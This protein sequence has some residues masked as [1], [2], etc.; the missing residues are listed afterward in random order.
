MNKKNRGRN[1]SQKKFRKEVERKEE[2]DGVRERG[3]GR[4][5]GWR[6]VD[7]GGGGGG[8]WCHFPWSCRVLKWFLRWHPGPKSCICGHPSSPNSC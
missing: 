2:K 5:W 1:K 8:V 7:L 3:K 4:K 6:G